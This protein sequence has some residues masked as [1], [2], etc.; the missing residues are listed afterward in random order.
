MPAKQ[1][2]DI[3]LYYADLGRH[4][5]PCIQRLNWSVRR[6]MPDAR[7]VLIT[8]TPHKKFEPFFDKV[9]DV[10]K[11]MTTTDETVCYD[12]VRSMVS[13]QMMTTRTT[14][15]VD[16][17]LEF[18]RPVEFSD[19]WDIGLLWRKRKPDQPINT[20]MILAQPGHHEFWVQYGAIAANLPL[21]LRGWWCDQLAFSVMLGTLHKAGDTVQAHDARVKLIDWLGACAPEEKANP[22][23]WAIHFKGDRKNGPRLQ[24]VA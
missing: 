11:A 22:D 14:L 10:S 2:E 16:P 17:D 1:P 13:W 24:V 6:T 5:M 3:V 7:L 21:K 4:Y 18:R 12:R 23:V 8:P 20:G 19:D 15:H 9:V